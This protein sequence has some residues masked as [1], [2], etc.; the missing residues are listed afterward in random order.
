MFQ[1]LS[2]KLADEICKYTNNYTWKIL[3]LNDKISTINGSLNKAAVLMMEDCANVD[4]YLIKPQ[5]LRNLL[6]LYY[7]SLIGAKAGS[8]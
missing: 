5:L 7:R 6:S 3:V 2:S 4:C 8:S 1:D